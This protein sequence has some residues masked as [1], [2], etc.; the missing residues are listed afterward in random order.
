MTALI[1]VTP[2]LGYTKMTQLETTQNSA[3]T[4]IAGKAP[5]VHQQSLETNLDRVQSLEPTS[6]S[7]APNKRSIQAATSESVAPYKKSKIDCPSCQV[8]P[9]KPKAPKDTHGGQYLGKGSLSLSSTANTLFN[10]AMQAA[11][12]LRTLSAMV[13]F[14]EKNQLSQEQI[15]FLKLSIQNIKNSFPVSIRPHEVFLTTLL[16]HN[17]RY[18][19]VGG[20]EEKAFLKEFANH[21]SPQD[22]TAS[23]QLAKQSLFFPGSSDGIAAV[24]RYIKT[25]TEADQLPKLCP[26]FTVSYGGYPEAAAHLGFEQI[27]DL[28]QAL[29]GTEP[30]VMPI[31]NPNNPLG[32]YEAPDQLIK[33]F[34]NDLPKG[35][36]VIVDESGLD[37]I[38]NEKDKSFFNPKQLTALEA[39]FQK[40]ITVFVVKSLTKITN[41]L[42]DPRGGIVTCLNPEI[43]SDF[44]QEQCPQY[45]S[46]AALAFYQTFYEDYDAIVLPSQEKC[47]QQNASMRNLITE[48]VEE[49]NQKMGAK[50]S[51]AFSGVPTMPYLCIKLGYSETQSNTTEQAFD[52]LIGDSDLS[53]AAYNQCEQDK[54]SIRHLADSYYNQ[55]ETGPYNAKGSMDGVIRVRVCNEK[56]AQRFSESL[57]QGLFNLLSNQTIT[58]I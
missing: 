7:E 51:V 57:Q 43:A 47:R 19:V 56:E 27:T 48:K 1:I 30:V 21:F 42:G 5:L 16:E 14:A 54:I 4:W 15:H 33:Q 44:E 46:P 17:E 10:G 50:L 22:V 23:Q 39:A 55:N 3:P 9:L 28:D 35:S 53:Q 31:V 18:A 6:S 29:Q 32:E 34:I 20:S 36:F 24:F 11:E 25:K 52:A 13:T 26:S 40:D 45:H 49:I 2:S 37:W 58:L 41:S 8:V 38:P 12:K